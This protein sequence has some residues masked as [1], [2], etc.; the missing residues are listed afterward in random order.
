M[1]NVILASKLPLNMDL[2]YHSRWLE[3]SEINNGGRAKKI[4]Q[5]LYFYVTIISYFLI[6]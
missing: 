2:F 4:I 1:S 6:L 3:Q 5:Y